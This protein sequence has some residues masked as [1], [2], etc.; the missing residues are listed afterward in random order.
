MII[1][2]ADYNNMHHDI[3][4]LSVAFLFLN[5]SL[6]KKMNVIVF[7]V[8]K[9]FGTAN[10]VIKENSVYFFVSISTILIKIVCNMKL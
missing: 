10:D 9:L 6:S 4:M 8:V 5:I 7:Y 1:S 2:A 3:I